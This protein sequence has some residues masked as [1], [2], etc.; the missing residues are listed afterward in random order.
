[1]IFK[2]DMND[3]IDGTSRLLVE[4]PIPG[5]DRLSYL[6]SAVLSAGTVPALVGVVLTVGPKEV[7]LWPFF[8]VTTGA[9]LLI[10]LMAFRHCLILAS[11]PDFAVGK[12]GLL[13]REGRIQN[14]YDWEGVQYC[15]W[16]HYE[17]GVL[18]IQVGAHRSWTGVSS[19]PT[20]LFRRIP[21]AYQ[22][23][24]EKAIQTMGKW[25]EGE[26]DWALGRPVS[27][28]NDSSGLKTALIDE[29]DGTQLALVEIPC[30]RRKVVASF[31]PALLWVCWGATMVGHEGAPMAHRWFAPI[32]FGGMAVIV[33]VS[34]LF[35]ASR[36]ELAVFEQGISLP[37]N[38]FPTWSSPR[39]RSAL[40]FLTWDEVSYCRW[41]R[42]ALG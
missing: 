2:R 24:V 35:R 20:R 34:A 13:L 17:P 40:G 1:M 12:D 37:F 10:S 7:L 16:S 15:H 23:Q 18:I 29:F 33:T 8:E 22:A 42:Y 14:H 19:P 5:S 25:V 28:A 31:F 30:S 4:V 27:W 26:S 3:E 9:L 6:M 11:R 39:N 38:G 41:S 32:F 21:E 36:P